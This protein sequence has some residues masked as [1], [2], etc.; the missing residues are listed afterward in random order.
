MT[1]LRDPIHFHWGVRQRP[2]PPK[3]PQTS[4]LGELGGAPDLPKETLDIFLRE[5]LGGAPDLSKRPWT[6][7][8]RNLAAPPNSLRDPGPRTSVSGGSAE[9][10]TSL[11]DSGHP[12]KELSSGPSQFAASHDAREQGT[13]VW[14]LA[15]RSRPRHTRAQSPKY[16]WKCKSTWKPKCASKCKSACT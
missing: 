16:K 4:C 13:L 8:L 10:P 11:S 1:S 5:Q 3:R 9:P 6:F 15:V 12:S 2:R 14:H 7:F